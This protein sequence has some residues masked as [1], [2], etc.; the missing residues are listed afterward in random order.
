MLLAGAANAECYIRSTSVVNSNAS[1]ERIADY[2]RTVLP[3]ADNKNRCQVTFRAYIGNKWYLA[4]GEEIANTPASLETACAKAK[5]SATS[6]ILE[7]VSGNK[8]TMHQDMIC[9]DEPLPKFKPYV[10]IG[11][12]VQESEVQ[13]HPIY[14]DNFRYRAALCRWFAE[15]TPEAGRINTKQGIMCRMR[16]DQK[17]WKVV[18]K[19]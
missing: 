9:T 10:K 18:D 17:L 7:S 6:N 14:P 8:I 2:K 19:W 1:I 3:T 11:D 13:P 15:A 16:S 5:Q 4:S 12:V